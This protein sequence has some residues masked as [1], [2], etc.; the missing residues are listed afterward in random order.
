MPRALGGSRYRAR[1]PL[2]GGIAGIAP[3][4]AGAASGVVNVAHQLGASL[5]LGILVTVFAATG[6]GTADARSLLA[7][8]VGTTLTAGT[9]MLAVAFV[10]VVVLILRP[11]LTA[12]LAGCDAHAATDA[13]Q[14]CDV[15]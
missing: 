15:R 2:A 5:G 8:R 3:E 11:R 1:S 9:G 10:L 7:E 12:G 4:D 13:E 6:A 14:L